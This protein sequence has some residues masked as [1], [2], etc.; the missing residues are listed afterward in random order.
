MRF[1]IPFGR[2]KNV[3]DEDDSNEWLEEYFQD[4]DEDEDEESEDDFP[5]LSF[6][7]DH[8]LFDTNASDGLDTDDASFIWMSHGK[9]ED[10]AFGYSE[11]ELEDVT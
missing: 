9:D 4:D 5:Y 7:F 10:Y 6:S 11:D 2:K 1:H 3:S 8:G